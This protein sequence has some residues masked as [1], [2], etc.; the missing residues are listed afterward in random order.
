LEQFHY[1]VGEGWTHQCQ[2]V[3]VTVSR[4]QPAFVSQM[5]VTCLLLIR[6][7]VFTCITSVSRCVLHAC[8]VSC[9]AFGVIN[10]DDD[11]YA[12]RV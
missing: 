10:D 3:N 7:Y 12:D 8:I 6:F 9:S 4:V 11:D 2:R 5:S 1:K